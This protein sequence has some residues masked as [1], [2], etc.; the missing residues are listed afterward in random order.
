[1]TTSP[2]LSGDQLREEEAL[3]AKIS[4]LLSDMESRTAE[5]TNTTS[6][7]LDEISK[8]LSDLEVSSQ[9]ADVLLDE[10]EKELTTELQGIVLDFVDDKDA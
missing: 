10:Q 7:I 3:K 9:A 8:D 6:G 4:S 1:M 2:L 5:F